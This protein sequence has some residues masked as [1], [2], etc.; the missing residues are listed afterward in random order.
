MEGE[1]DS[2]GTLEFSGVICHLCFDWGIGF[3]TGYVCQN[4]QNCIQKIGELYI[5]YI[6]YNLHLNKLNYKKK[7]TD[8][9]ASLR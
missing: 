9:W 8:V 5:I 2:K 1:V 6:L 3:M 7:T 4:S